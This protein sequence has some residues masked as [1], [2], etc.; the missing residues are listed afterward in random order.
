MVKLDTSTPSRNSAQLVREGVRDLLASSPSY[1][2]LA[3]D[4]R[5]KIAKDTVRVAAYM[6]DPQRLLAAEF[7]SPLLA[8]VVLSE[9]GRRS[10]D[11][12]KPVPDTIQMNPRSMDTLLAAVDFPSFVADLIQGVFGAI[13]NASVQQ[14]EAYAALI[15]A[16]SLSV[17]Q[18]VQ[19][20]IT[21]DSARHALVN[22][23]PNAAC[24]AGAGTRRLKLHAPARSPSLTMLAAAIGL[25]EP[26]AEPQQV[27][28]VKRIIAGARRRL[29]RN[30]QQILATMILMGINRMV[31]MHG[32]VSP[33][34]S[35]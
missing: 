1:H 31:F 18:F 15:T 28:E 35:R 23:F 11:F 13:V 30:R 17:D 16:V 8:G 7:R 33:K 12:S 2:V 4:R 24:W 19:A 10:A 34:L 20:N 26:V 27:R 9:P 32:A 25:R 21:E 29:A 3:A 6:V 22:E 14:M 5:R